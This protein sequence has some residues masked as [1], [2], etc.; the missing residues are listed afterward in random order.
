V[1]YILQKKYRENRVVMGGASGYFIISLDF[2]LMYGLSELKN[3]D[4]YKKSVAGG[5]VAIPRIL[6][7]FTKYGIH[8]TWSVVGKI[9]MASDSY[10]Y[11]GNLIDMIRN[12]QGQEIGSHTFSHIHCLGE[13]MSE[14]VF[15]SDC[16]AFEKIASQNSIKAR[17]FVLY[18]CYLNE[19]YEMQSLNMNEIVEVVRK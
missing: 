8:A 16:S 10:H 9:M 5:K 19:K 14:E 2:E 17:S 18:F 4:Y 13:G 11:A 7:L 3:Q 1:Y 15:E 6:E 12:V